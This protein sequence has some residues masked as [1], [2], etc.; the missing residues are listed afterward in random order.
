M[1]V[2]PLTVDFRAGGNSLA[3][4]GPGWSAP[5]SHGCW[6]DAPEAVVT[7]TL[8]P[9][10]RYRLTADL[11]PFVAAGLPSQRIVVAAG[12]VVLFE[13]ACMG[14]LHLM[15]DVP[16][17]ALAPDGTLR[18]L[19][20]FPDAARASDHGAAGD[21]RRLGFCFGQVTLLPMGRIGHSP[22]AAAA[23]IDPAPGVWRIPLDPQSRL[24]P[25]AS[26]GTQP[27]PTAPPAGERPR[28]AVVTMVYN[29][30]VYLPIWQRHYSRQV[31]AENCYVI[32]HG[33]DPGLGVD[34]PGVQT[35]RLPR[36][37]FD[38]ILQYTFAERFCASLLCWYDW[39]LF[40]DADE[41]LVADPA[42][43]PS[44]AEYCRR[45][46]PE[47]V[48]AIGLNV[49]HLPA[50]EP[51]FD[52]SR[53]VL[54]QRRWA[55]AASSMCKPLLIRRPVVWPGGAHSADAPVAFDHLYM[56]H[57]RWFDMQ[58]GLIR[59]AKTR[60][61]A[62]AHLQS[63][64][65]QRVPDATFLSQFHRF[66][67]LPRLPGVPFDPAQEPLRSFLHAVE[68]SQTG[69]EHAAYRIDLGIWWNE[70][71]EIPERFRGLF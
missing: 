38:P 50:E 49:Q 24:L 43:A 55:F 6:S 57:L 2:A 20:R 7:L 63:G 36:S 59:L 62:W 25:T 34:H 1:S 70:L 17:T 56:F 9:A 28:I 53:P 8:D 60:S 48:T 67:G 18:L 47:V 52:P 3:H 12:G 33:S 4:A 14:P 15:L 68:E 40:C 13:A 26:A 69:R 71:W 65:H 35:I 5:E 41:I 31:G 16:P 54:Q 37:P 45:P 11:Q 30:P 42:V 46:L 22:A 44:L 23:R 61:M 29:E 64:D 66:A 58:Q 32:D 10:Y 39:V 21:G 27:G 51:D 19:F